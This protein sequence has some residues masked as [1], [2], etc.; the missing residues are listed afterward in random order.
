MEV[1][2]AGQL[3]ADCHPACAGRRAGNPPTPPH[4]APRSI[5]HP[6][7]KL[8]PSVGGS[9]L[10]GPHWQPCLA[11]GPT[12]WREE[13]PYRGGARGQGVPARQGAGHTP[14]RTPRIPPRRALD[15]HRTAAA[16][17]VTGVTAAARGGGGLLSSTVEASA[18][19]A[20]AAATEE[21][22]EEASGGSSPRL[23]PGVCGQR[24]RSG[25]IAHRL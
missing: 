9:R 8:K 17:L 22:E 11:T 13:S 4:T 20:A 24:G 23:L 18:A 1:S 3:Q 2:T 19:V 21:E 5:P 16:G 6:P 10:A 14:I 7:Q 15:R 25:R 12:A